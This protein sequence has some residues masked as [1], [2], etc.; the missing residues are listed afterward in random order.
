[1]TPLDVFNP[2]NLSDAG[3][4]N[5]P[6]RAG[7]LL[8]AARSFREAPPCS[9]SR[10][11]GRRSA[12]TFPAGVLLARHIPLSPPITFALYTASDFLGALVAIRSWLRSGVTLGACARCTG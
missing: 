7:A 12:P 11:F 2:A 5:G 9:S 3:G 1:M 4:L 10:S 6:A 8:D